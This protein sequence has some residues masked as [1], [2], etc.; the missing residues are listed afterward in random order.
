MKKFIIVLLSFIF[1]VDASNAQVMLKKMNNSPA[2]TN[3]VIKKPIVQQTVPKQPPQ[4][5]KQTTSGQNTVKKTE[6]STSNTAGTKMPSPALDN[7][8]ISF[9]SGEKGKSNH[10]ILVIEIDDSKQR[11]AADYS[12]VG[13]TT[14]VEDDRY[15]GHIKY[16]QFVPEF[17]PGENKS[18]STKLDASVPQTVELNGTLPY[19]V[20]R[21]A[22]LSDFANGGSISLAII[23]KLVYPPI[24]PDLWNINNFTVYLSFD[25]D[26]T[27]PHKMTWNGFTLSPTAHSRTLK[28]D[29][30][31]NPIQ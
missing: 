20:T 31:F 21:N 5:A 3:S 8:T 30:N 27:S 22:V 16:V 6:M 15:K 25:G 24:G 12:E 4:A 17:D 28:F 2:V 1:F 10:T 29:K 23:P 9:T 7:A 19:T 13:L 18:L 26:P 14:P 11:K